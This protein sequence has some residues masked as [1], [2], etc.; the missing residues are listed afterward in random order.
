M[1]YRLP[2]I[3]HSHRATASG[4]LAPSPQRAQIGLAHGGDVDLA[5]QRLQRVAQR[6]IVGAFR[7]EQH[8]GIAPLGSSS[9]TRSY[10]A[11]RPS[12]V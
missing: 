10:F 4:E 6:L 2:I 3:S 12:L 9:A 1:F 7:R 8:D 11:I 5:Q